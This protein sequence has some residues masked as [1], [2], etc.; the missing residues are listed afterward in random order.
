MID[1]ALLLG[2]GWDVMLRP[3]SVIVVVSKT[4]RWVGD[5]RTID[6]WGRISGATAQ[7]AE[8]EKMRRPQR[9]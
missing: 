1:A 2:Y 3:Q 9:E 6:R 4:M 8:A 5:D 7:E